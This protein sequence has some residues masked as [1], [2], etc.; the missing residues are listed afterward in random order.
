MDEMIAQK[1]MRQY[2]RGGYPVLAPTLKGRTVA[3]EWLLAHPEMVA[4]TAEA[5]EPAEGETV[6]EE[7]EVVEKYTVLQKALYHWRRRTADEGGVPTYVLMGNELMMRIAESHPQTMEE[8]AALP[9]MG[10]QRLERYGGVILDLVKLHPEAAGDT[11]LLS[12][13]RNEAATQEA[14][15][16]KSYAKAPAARTVSPQ[17]ERRIYL[18]MQELRQKIAVRERGKP[19]L[20]ANNTLLKA[21]AEQAPSSEEVLMSIMGFRSSGSA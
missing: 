7:A 12:T 8:L 6:E 20:I 11:V 2:E 17:V 18:K 9:G 3:E 4:P 19:Y 13:Q 10:T 14:S 1:F 15:G 16:E 21:I 5:V